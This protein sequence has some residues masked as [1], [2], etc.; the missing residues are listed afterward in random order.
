VPDWAQ[1]GGMLLRTELVLIFGVTE[2][3]E[4]KA[5]RLC[6]RAFSVHLHRSHELLREPRQSA[7]SGR[8]VSWPAACWDGR[9]RCPRTEQHR[10]GQTNALRMHLDTVR[11]DLEGHHQCHAAGW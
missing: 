11:L 7:L 9:G 4:S 5:P 1:K 2:A 8:P 6:P 10:G 3:V